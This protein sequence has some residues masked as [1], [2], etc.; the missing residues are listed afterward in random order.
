MEMRLPTKYLT[1]KLDREHKAEQIAKPYVGQTK[2]PF[3]G[4]KES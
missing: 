1:G 4:Y 3:L 2:Q